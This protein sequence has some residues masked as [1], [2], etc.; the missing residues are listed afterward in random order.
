MCAVD[1]SRAVAIGW[2][3]RRRGTVR[4]IRLSTRA[5]EAAT[6]PAQRVARNQALVRRVNEEIRKLSETRRRKAR[7]VGLVCECSRS[8]CFAPIS[9]ALDAYETLRRDPRHYLVAPGH[10]WAPLEERV[11]VRTDSYWIIASRG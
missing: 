6:A 8:R 3:R 1:G 5:P 9:V 10:V 2:S 11:V 4:E 7:L